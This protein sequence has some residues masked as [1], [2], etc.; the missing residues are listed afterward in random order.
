MS[1]EFAEFCECRVFVSDRKAVGAPG[2]GAWINLGRLNKS[3]GNLKP[4]A[5]LNADHLEANGSIGTTAPSL[6]IN[7]GA[8]FACDLAEIE[9]VA[10][11]LFRQSCKVA[12]LSASLTRSVRFSG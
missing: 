3:A 9:S 10:P 11:K 7:R 12:F 4:L 1:L 8:A 5:A 2:C 6:R